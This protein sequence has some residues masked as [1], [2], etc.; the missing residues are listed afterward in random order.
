MTP[1]RDTAD[2]VWVIS[3]Q[4]LPTG[5]PQL[6]RLAERWQLAALAAT[7]VFPPHVPENRTQFSIPRYAQRQ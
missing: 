3:L 4:H 7:H 1:T 6:Y 5:L 2:S